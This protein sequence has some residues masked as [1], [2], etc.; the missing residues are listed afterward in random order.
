MKKSGIYAYLKMYFFKIQPS[1]SPQV[2]KYQ[3]DMVNMK[4]INVLK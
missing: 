2:I 3:Y 4:A 1:H